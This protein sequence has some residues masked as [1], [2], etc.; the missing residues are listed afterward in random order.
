MRAIPIKLAW[1]LAGEPR[2]LS[3]HSVPSIPFPVRMANN[4]ASLYTPELSIREMTLQKERKK[5]DFLRSSE[6]EVEHINQRFL[7]L[8]RII[9]KYFSWNE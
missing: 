5:P 3:T 2:P 4:H 1:K 8:A 6:D 7:T 9:Y